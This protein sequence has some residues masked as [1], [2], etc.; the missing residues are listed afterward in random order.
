MICDFCLISTERVTFQ[1]YVTALK[2]LFQFHTVCY[3]VLSIVYAFY[4]NHMQ[5]IPHELCLTIFN[6]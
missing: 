6:E 4:A 1:L 3:F 2:A 5:T